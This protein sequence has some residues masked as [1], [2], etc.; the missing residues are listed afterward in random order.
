MGMLD[1]LRNLFKS[2]KKEEIADRQRQQQEERYKKSMLAAQ[3]L[4]LVN[5]IKRINSFDSS[6]WNLT[7]TSSSMLERKSL[8]ELEKLKQTLSNRYQQLTQ[9]SQRRNP[10]MEALEEA[11]WSGQKPEHLTDTEF[12]R[13][14]RD[15]RW[16]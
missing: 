1:N 12:D 5:G 14:Q 15:G 7:N 11:K 3:I 9:Q 4:D 2:S 13:L 16:E 8:P 6:L 10:K